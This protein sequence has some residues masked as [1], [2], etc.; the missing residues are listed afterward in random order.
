MSVSPSRSWWQVW[1]ESE[2]IATG[3]LVHAG[4]LPDARFLLHIRSLQGPTALLA[5]LGP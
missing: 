1:M 5:A 2:F 3:L 4:F